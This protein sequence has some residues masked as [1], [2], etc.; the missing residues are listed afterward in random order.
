MTTV[1]VRRFDGRTAG[2]LR[3]SVSEAA[4]NHACAGRMNV[5]VA[6]ASTGSAGSRE[7]CGAAGSA[8]ALGSGAGSAGVSGSGAGGG[9]TAVAGS[10]GA[11]SGGAVLAS[12]EGAV[13]S[14]DGA[15]GSGGAAGSVRSGTRVADSGADAGAPGAS[16][17]DGSS[18]A[19]TGSGVGGT[20]GGAAGGAVEALGFT[21]GSARASST[22]HAD[23][24]RALWGA[25]SGARD[26]TAGSG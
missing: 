1:G 21:S 24:S 10:G 19:G 9:D 15:A 13:G 17:P 8:D 18:D 23:Q 14:G 16:D 26:G 22:G 12:G 7:D 25:G 6:S 2:G 5:S 11:V 3:A 4:P 20:T